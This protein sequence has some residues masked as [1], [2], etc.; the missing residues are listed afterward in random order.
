MT[1]TMIRVS[2]EVAREAKVA[3]V[4]RDMTMKAFIEE[5]IRTAAAKAPPKKK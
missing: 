3:A 5:A 4:L 1:D 2:K